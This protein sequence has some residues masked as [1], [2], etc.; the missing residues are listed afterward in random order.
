MERRGGT[1]NVNEERLHA[2]GSTCQLPPAARPLP[3]N[4]HP[5]VR[6]FGSRAMCVRL[7]PPPVHTRAYT[8]THSP[9]PNAYL[10]HTSRSFHP[11]S[12]EPPVWQP[13]HVR[14]HTR[15]RERAPG[16]LPSAAL[17]ADGAV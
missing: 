17:A 8:P 7:P 16:G 6:Q 10:A 4:I 11:V 3:R 1:N 15:S 5:P 13:C 14:A 2:P 9:P 12:A